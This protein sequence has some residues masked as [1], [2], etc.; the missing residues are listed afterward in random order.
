MNYVIAILVLAAL[1]VPII[2]SRNIGKKLG[3]YDTA[4]LQLQNETAAVIAGAAGIGGHLARIETQL[5]DVRERQNQLEASTRVEQSYSQAIRLVQEG[6]DIDQLVET[7]GLVRDEAEL[8]RTF[9]R[10]R[11]AG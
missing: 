5:N 6:A 8:I 3:Q 1:L 9:Y 11:Q 10:R 2:I 4:L 7:C